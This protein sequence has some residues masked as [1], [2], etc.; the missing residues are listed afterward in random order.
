MDLDHFQ[1]K[2][3]FYSLLVIPFTNT[4]K[5]CRF[6]LPDLMDI[7]F[8]VSVAP[9]PSSGIQPTEFPPPSSNKAVKLDFFQISDCPKILD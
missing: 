6:L 5:I 2:P 7:I 9:A 1:H 3:V 8:L 4:K